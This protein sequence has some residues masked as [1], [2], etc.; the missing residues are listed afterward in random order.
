[1]HLIARN[2]IAS[3][4]KQ[5]PEAETNFLVWLKEFQYRIPKGF[6]DVE[7]LVTTVEGGVGNTDYRIR[8]RA[9]HFLKTAYIDWVGTAD[10]YRAHTQKEL[11]NLRALYPDMKVGHAVKI[12]NVTLHPPSFDELVKNRELKQANVIIADQTPVPEI[13][14]DQAVDFPFKTNAEYEAG[15][16][17]AIALFNTEPITLEVE[18][19]IPKLVHYE[20]TFIKFPELTP[21]AVIKLKIQEWRFGNDYPLDLIKL[22]GSKEELD[23]FLSGD[24]PLSK[25]AIGVLYNYL[26]INFMSA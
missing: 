5:H 24:K 2:K 4:I 6:K 20:N 26:K 21:L 12:T 10:E 19:L 14:S 23:Q 9:N 13:V 16:A 18:T 7:D 25:H 8:Y 1:M 3:Y 22:I 11:E 17:R 15:L